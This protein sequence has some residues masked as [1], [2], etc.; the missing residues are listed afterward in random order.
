L[1]FTAAHFVVVRT[2]QLYSMLN[3]VDIDDIAEV[4]LRCQR[5]ARKRRLFWFR[6]LE[7]GFFQTLI[8]TILPHSAP[9]FTSKRF[10]TPPHALIPSPF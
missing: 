2:F 3:A 5:G 9:P 7:F 10:L 4:E 8:Q 1:G 6:I